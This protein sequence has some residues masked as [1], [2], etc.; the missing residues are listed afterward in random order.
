MR[1]RLLALGLLLAGCATTPEPVPAANDVENGLQLYGELRTLRARARRGEAP[2]VHAELAQKLAEHPGDRQL[3]FLDAAVSIPGD[4]SWQALKKLSADDARDPWP[5]VGMG[6]TYT[7]WKMYP[8]AQESFARAEAIRPGFLPTAISRA[9][10]LLRAHDPG[11]KAAFE[12]LKA[13]ADVPEVHAGLGEVALAAG[14]VATARA[15]L[16]LANKGDPTDAEV[17]AARVQLALQ[18][19]DLPGAIE[20]DRNLAALQPGDGAVR[21]ELGKLEE[22]QGDLD[23]AAKDLARAGELRGVDLETAQHLVAVAKA[24]HDEKLLAGALEQLSRV[25]KTNPAPELELAELRAQQKDF[26]GA[27]AH[28]KAALER[29]PKNLRAQLLLARAYRDGGKSREAIEAYRAL[30]ERPE[31]PAEAKDE[32]APLLANLKL[33]EKPLAGDVNKI[34]LRFSLDLESFY[35]KR[36]KEK[37][38]LKG[39]LRLAVDVDASGK[40]NAVGLTQQ[41]LD[42]ALLLDHAYFT[43]KGAQFPK[44]KRSPV[45]EVELKP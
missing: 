5:F 36:L 37:P 20:A 30:T 34:N 31:A 38:R 40:V 10:L 23:A 1:R 41:G 29:D 39:T 13:R 16:D 17:Q 3:Q 14:D 32:L 9:Q 11:A 28:D 42:D 8:Q 4:A 26:A 24:R 21:L 45:F 18:A 6:L 15:E 7:A 25:D 43:M 22:Q 33:S 35:K 27:E 19:H 2:A 44:A 12:A